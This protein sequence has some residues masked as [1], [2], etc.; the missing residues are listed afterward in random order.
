MSKLRF[1]RFILSQ[2]NSCDLI[3]KKID[4]LLQNIGLR[5][6]YSQVAFRFVGSIPTLASNQFAFVYKGLVEVLG[7]S[8]TGNFTC[9]AVQT[10]RYQD[11]Q[12]LVAGGR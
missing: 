6:I 5:A 2:E 1:T 7:Q 8:F 11:V 9:L 10:G 12:M 4:L 3:S